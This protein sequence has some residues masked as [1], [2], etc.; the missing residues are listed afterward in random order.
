MTPGAVRSLQR[1]MDNSDPQLSQSVRSTDGFVP[2][3]S[4]SDPAPDRFERAQEPEID[5][6]RRR[7]TE[8]IYDELRNRDLDILRRKPVRAQALWLLPFAR[9]MGDRWEE[10]PISAFDVYDRKH[11]PDTELFIHVKKRYFK[12]KG[13]FS[14]FL[15]P[16]RVK[17]IKANFVRSFSMTYICTRLTSSTQHSP[18][19][20]TSPKLGSNYIMHLWQNPH[21]TDWLT[22]QNNKSVL[23]TARSVMRKLSDLVRTDKNYAGGLSGNVDDTLAGQSRQSETQQQLFRQ[24]YV[25]HTIPKELGVKSN[26]DINTDGAF[27][28]FEENQFPHF[29]ILVAVILEFTVYGLV[30]GVHF[31][32]VA[33]LQGMG[34]YL[35]LLWI[36]TWITG[37]STMFIILWFRPWGYA[38]S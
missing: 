29:L 14:R 34:L 5:S 7:K 3:D 28:L 37:L 27:F 4:N 16:Q 21:H 9:P 22:Y 26:F 13:R 38:C 32:Y 2:Y 18:S 17:S 19:I 10:F 36:S 31:R 1:H 12:S 15:S 23:D 25:F 20:Y 6:D 35:R 24:S 30:L 11:S 33:G 8:S